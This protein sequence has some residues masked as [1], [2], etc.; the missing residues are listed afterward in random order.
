[1]GQIQVSPTAPTTKIKYLKALTHT[2]TLEEKQTLLS[3]PQRKNKNRIMTP[4]NP[5]FPSNPLTHPEN[6][7]KPPPTP[8]PP[9]SSIQKLKLSTFWTIQLI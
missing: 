8:S 7:K 5:Y 9:L 2:P 4:L 6:P 3:P 1:L